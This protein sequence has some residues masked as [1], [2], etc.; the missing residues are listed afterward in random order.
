MKREQGQSE[1]GAASRLGLKE[2]YLRERESSLEDVGPEWETR[3]WHD[4]QSG[5]WRGLLGSKETWTQRGLRYRGKKISLVRCGGD[6]AATQREERGYREGGGRA[7]T[8]L[9]GLPES[10]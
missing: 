2:S 4:E 5:F 6:G 7:D 1:G 10:V 3:P 9:P 8:D